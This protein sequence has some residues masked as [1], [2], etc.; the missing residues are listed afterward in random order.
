M[1]RTAAYLLLLV[2][3][4]TAG[5]TAVQPHM[6]PTPVVFRDAQLD[7]TVRLPSELRS[8]DVSVVRGAHE[9]GGM[10]GHGYWYANDWISTDVALSLRHSI[11]PEQRCLIPG[12][13]KFVWKFP[14]NYVDCLAQRLGAAFPE[15]RRSAPKTP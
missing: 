2:F 12:P 11:P 5:C 9:M 1:N 3:A 4:A 13:R 14:D 10:R 15:T 7:M 8:V 6:I